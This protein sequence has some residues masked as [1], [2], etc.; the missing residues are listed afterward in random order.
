MAPPR[1]AR[2]P[3]F[4]G[5]RVERRED[6]FN[7]FKASFQ[8]IGAMRRMD[9]PDRKHY[10]GHHVEACESHLRTI[11]KSTFKWMDT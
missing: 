8:A 1:A 5:S 9:Q 6:W 11:G 7:E 10:L 2:D 4:T 3:A